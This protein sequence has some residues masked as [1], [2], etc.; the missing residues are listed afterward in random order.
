MNCVA[1]TKIPKKA[2]KLYKQAELS[3]L[4]S[5][6]NLALTELNKSIEIFPKYEEAY[7][8][9][10]KILI[11]IK[12]FDLAL[13][14]LDKYLEVNPKIDHKIMYQKGLIFMTQEDYDLAKAELTK[15]SNS[16][17]C[18]DRLKEKIVDKIKECDDRLELM[19]NKVNL[20]PISLGDKINSREDEYLPVFTAEGDRIFFT[21][22]IG[23]GQ[24]A[25]EDFYFS[26]KDENGE[27]L[28]AQDMGLPINNP[29]TQEGAM[30][31]SQ[32]GNK[33]FFAQRNPKKQGG[34]DI[35]YSYQKKGEWIMPM[36]LGQPISTEAWDSQPSI[37]ADGTELFFA[38]RR[39]GGK[40]GID[41]WVS[42]LKNNRW[43]PPRNL[44]EINTPEDEQCPFI[45]PD[46]KT[47]FFSSKG[48]RG[49]GDA[50]LF[51][52]ERLP[53]GTWSTPKNLGYPINTVENENSLIVDRTGKTA[54]Y[55]R[56]VEGNGFDLFYFDLPEDLQT[57]FVTY[58]KGK[59]IDST[60]LKSISARVTITDLETDEVINAIDSDPVTGEF[61]LTLTVGKNYAFTAQKEDYV[62]Y[63][64]NFSLK[65]LENADTFDLMIKLSPIKKAQ[66]FVLKNVFFASNK[67]E[68]LPESFPELDKLVKLLSEN[69][70]KKL[71]I[72]G[73]TDNV[74]DPEKNLVLSKNRAKS[75][76]EYLISKNIESNRLK[77]T[78]KGETEPIA[79]NE[80]PEGRS[81]NRRTEFYLY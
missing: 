35:Y 3:Y 42:V 71:E 2:E 72:T 26:T 37:S 53:D 39:A 63:S 27:W 65:G 22:R 64:D 23:S 8:L 28:E 46:G 66:S 29:L 17:N 31:I 59:V 44:K 14:A 47:L 62:F 7:K 58:V 81:Q 6:K 4:S 76:Q 16:E 74:G 41:I 33:I 61:L 67:Y 78:G 5:D 13:E 50:D 20:E 49:L 40:G 68:L 11:E 51:K 24:L 55:S 9:K 52:S 54:Y 45:H 15:A 30:S 34:M 69:P 19:K 48:L 73:H 75:V 70:E 57:E 1:Q 36:N 79:D 77:Y 38:S 10:S 18:K 80:T 25:N 60:D 12:Q 32:D 21:R 56:Y 43:E